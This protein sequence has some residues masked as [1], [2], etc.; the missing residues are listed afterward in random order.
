MNSLYDMKI[1]WEKHYIFPAVL[2]RITLVLF[3]NLLLW[4]KDGTIWKMYE[5]RL[6]EYTLIKDIKL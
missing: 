3:N 5:F 1:E 2:I 4:H 6:Y